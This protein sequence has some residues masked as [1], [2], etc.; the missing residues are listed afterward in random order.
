[1]YN[2]DLF[3]EKEKFKRNLI[4]FI[5][6]ILLHNIKKDFKNLYNRVV[7]YTI[8]KGYFIFKKIKLKKRNKLV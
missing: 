7:L 3:K 6:L 4:K 5:I 2:L 8:R 1:V